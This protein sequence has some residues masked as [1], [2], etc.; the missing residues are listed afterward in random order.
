MKTVYQRYRQLI[1]TL[2]LLGCCISTV[3]TAICGTVTL[4]E[5][6][7][8]FALTAQHYGA[9]LATLVTLAAFFSLRRYYRYFLLLTFLL[10][11]SGLINFTAVQTRVGLSFGDVQI[12]LD[13]ILL[14]VGFLTY[15]LNH[16]IINSYLFALIKPSDEKIARAYRDEIE[17]FKENFVHKSTKELSRIVT[18]NKLV[19]AAVGAARQLLKERA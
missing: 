5:V 2:V 4:N 17:R 7:Y 19:P 18:E 6:S 11:I 1:P 12:G 3:F 10:G 14:S 16:R 8:A 9:S 13:S 15:L